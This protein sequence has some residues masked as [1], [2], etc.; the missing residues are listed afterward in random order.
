M[1]KTIK[2]IQKFLGKKL[3]KTLDYLCSNAKVH[4]YRWYVFT[5]IICTI[6]WMFVW[7]YSVLMPIS[8]IQEE[9]EVL[10]QD[11]K[12]IKYNYDIVYNPQDIN[13]KEK[14]WW[15]IVELYIDLLNSWDYQNACT[16]VNTTKCKM[17]DV[18]QFTQ[19][20]E[21]KKR[22]LTAKYK[23]WENIIRI[24]N[25]E[26]KYENIKTEVW[27]WEVEYTY[28]TEDRP[29]REIRQYYILTRPDWSKEISKELSEKIEKD[30]K[31][32]TV[33]ALKYSLENT[34]CIK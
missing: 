25:P 3:T 10:W 31:D 32:I 27:C 23:D 28:N 22:V 30:W 26:V 14:T 21:D 15:E 18:K 12:D 19:W 4:N 16:L 8:K 13:T 20:V 5:A 17:Y 1:I 7:F 33:S 9:V 29:I 6:I 11:I 2:N 34:I 24:W